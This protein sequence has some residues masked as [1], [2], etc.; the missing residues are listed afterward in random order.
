M[1]A[2]AVQGKIDLAEQLCYGRNNLKWDTWRME[3]KDDTEYCF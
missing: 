1:E 3:G 2:E